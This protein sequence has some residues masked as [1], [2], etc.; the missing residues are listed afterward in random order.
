MLVVN[1][2]QLAM[3]K[4][5]ENYLTNRVRCMTNLQGVLASNMKAYR[6]VLGLSQVKL[7]E[8][9]NT[10]PNYIALI[11]TGKRFPSPPMLDRIARAL[12]V[13]SL[14]LFSKKQP[15]E[16]FIQKLRENIIAD[17]KKVIDDRLKE[18]RDA[19]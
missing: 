7:A 12:D 9:V 11:E 17:I 18:L 15:E 10:A 14:Q 19:P 5:L 13:D 2:Y 3:L 6:S 8:L 1:N 16:E 4:I